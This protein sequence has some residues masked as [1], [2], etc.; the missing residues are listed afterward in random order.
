M[1]VSPRHP[2]FSKIP[3]PKLPVPP[4]RERRH[5]DPG[6]QPERTSLS[7]QRTVVSMLVFGSVLL[8]WSQSYLAVTVVIATLLLFISLFVLISQRKRYE[9]AD[10]GV[11]R[12]HKDA[13]YVAVFALFL[14]MM[15]IGCMGILFIILDATAG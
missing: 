12:G 11:A 1:A 15:V 6:L 10:E 14:G 7:W 9:D 5:R 4:P 2:R 8:R 13:N 3:T